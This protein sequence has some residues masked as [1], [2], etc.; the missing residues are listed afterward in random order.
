MAS[1]TNYFA[2]FLCWRVSVQTNLVI[3]LIAICC[4]VNCYLPVFMMVNNSAV[5]ETRGTVNIINGIG[6]ALVA[7]G[8]GAGPSIGGL[9]FAWS[10]RN[11]EQQV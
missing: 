10:E 6:Q 4:S 8:R 2:L 3:V 9:S 7:I 1:D 5:A 11:G